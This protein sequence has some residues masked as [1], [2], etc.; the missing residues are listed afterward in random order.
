MSKTCIFRVS[1]QGSEKLVGFDGGVIVA[2]GMDPPSPRAS[3]WAITTYAFAV[4]LTWLQT[5][6]RGGP[7]CLS[8][9]AR[10]PT[11]CG[12]PFSSRM[13]LVVCLRGRLMTGRRPL[14]GDLNVTLDCA[15]H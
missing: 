10:S 6:D 8:R 3:P 15:S 4:A 9:I 11:R 2:T 13:N 7:F 1:E 12:W 14:L 5:K